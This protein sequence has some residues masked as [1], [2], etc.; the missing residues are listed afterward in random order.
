M[1]LHTARDCSV[2]IIKLGIESR[3]N[4]EWRGLE[5]EKNRCNIEKESVNKRESAVIINRLERSRYEKNVFVHIE[6]YHSN[7][8]Y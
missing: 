4:A 5:T 8:L 3:M 7:S 6:P 2:V 1:V